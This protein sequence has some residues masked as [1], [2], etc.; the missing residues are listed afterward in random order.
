MKKYIEIYSNGTIN[1]NFNFSKSIK[2]LKFFE[3]DNL[4]FFLNIK[5][6][7]YSIKNLINYSK[8]KKKYLY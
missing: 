4:N 5:E 7:R 6:K 8:Y 1:Y 3:K 2:K